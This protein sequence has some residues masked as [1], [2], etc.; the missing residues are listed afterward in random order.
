M[1]PYGNLIMY[2]LVQNMTS[3]DEEERKA[4]FNWKNILPVTCSYNKSKNNKIVEDDLDKLK[5]RLK[6]FNKLNKK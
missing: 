1:E 2:T 4:A 3:P 6:K 5:D